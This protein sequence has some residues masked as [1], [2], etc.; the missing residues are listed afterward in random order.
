MAGW[1]KRTSE[2]LLKFLIW[3]GVTALACLDGQTGLQLPHESCSGSL[4]ARQAMMKKRKRGAAGRGK[5]IAIEGEG[6]GEEGV[7]EGRGGR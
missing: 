7:E 2:Q 3:L 5:G 6:M 1:G 4:A